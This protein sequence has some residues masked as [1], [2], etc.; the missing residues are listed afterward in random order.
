MEEFNFN[1]ED[2]VGSSV[3][4]LKEDKNKNLDLQPL[5]KPKRRLNMQKFARKVE[6]DLDNI[7]F[8]IVHPAN[9]TNDL[10]LSQNK[11][12]NK[13][14]NKADNKT[15]NK[16]DNKADNKTDNYTICGLPN[17]Y[18][19]IIINILL[20]MLLNNKFVIDIINNNIPIISKYNSPWPNL[21]LRSVVFGLIIILV[22]KY[23]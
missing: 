21:V 8:D 13:A 2:N 5:L 4:K 12:N 16:A 3:S 14:D 9:V 22:K 6:N 15:D 7:T 19:D 23:T 1:S 20:F 17:K 18:R 11:A 10:L